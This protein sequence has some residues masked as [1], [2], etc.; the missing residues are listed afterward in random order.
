[1]RS[2]LLGSVA[3]AVALMLQSIPASSQD[4]YHGA[5][6]TIG[7]SYAGHGRARPQYQH[8][9]YAGGQGP[10]YATGTGVA[11]LAAGALIGGAV[12][13][14]YQGYYPVE[15]YPVYSGQSY[16]YID[17]TPVENNGDAVAY[18]E[19]TYRSYSPASGTYLGYDGF[20]H[21]CP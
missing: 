13:S 14:Q 10:R 5:H 4:V 18:C 2:S 11:A 20:R 8:R 19:Q 12:A 21:P 3:M 6:A 17:S 15:T 16:V 7:H 1:M 9:G